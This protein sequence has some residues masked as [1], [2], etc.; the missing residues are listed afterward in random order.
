MTVKRADVE[1]TLAAQDPEELLS[2]LEAA[3][4]SPRGAQTPSEL[5]CRI[6][7]A[8]WWSYCTPLG[9]V[10]DGTTLDDIVEHVAHRL[11]VSHAIEAHMDPWL[12]VRSLTRALIREL[13]GVHGISLDDLDH[14]TRTRVWPS[15]RRTLAF[16]AGASGSFGASWASGRALAFLRGPIGRLLPLI[17][18]IAPYVGVVRTG[19]AAVNVVAGPLGVAMSVLTINQA[20]GTNYH[21]LVPLLLGVGA[22]GPD[23]VVDAEE[24]GAAA[25]F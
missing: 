9:Y 12:Q 3:R 15:W 16:G 6:T 22:L 13:E 19:A 2:I 24:L 20:L 8:L 7:D 10:A 11:R 21:Q 25:A 4:V 14:E 23:P 5:A 1:A 17:P 18:P